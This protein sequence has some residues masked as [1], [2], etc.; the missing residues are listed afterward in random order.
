MGGFTT[1][2]FCQVCRP[3]RRLKGE[4]I[5]I[6]ELVME[7]RR[8]SRMVHSSLIQCEMNVKEV[9]HLPWHRKLHGSVFPNQAFQV[10]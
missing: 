6:R 2:N 7:G 5:P 8:E 10:F 4:C 9:G 1:E 3:G